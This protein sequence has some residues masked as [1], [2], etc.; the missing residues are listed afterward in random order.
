MLMFRELTEEE[1]QKVD[2]Y[3]EQ[4]QHIANL[5]ISKLEKRKEIEYFKERKSWDFLP[6]VFSGLFLVSQMVILVLDVVFGCLYGFELVTRFAIAI[7]FA[8]MAPI[9]AIVAAVLFVKS[10]N[11]YL[12]RN[13][14]SQSYMQKALR[15]G[16][17][18]RWMRLAKLQQEYE[19]INASLRVLKKENNYL[20][21]AV[22]EIE[23][24]QFQ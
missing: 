8:S 23:K 10:L 11:T 20:K 24:N 22:E 5:E 7:A 13:S 4:K 12:L 19:E 17:E 2:K 6:V 14:K 9:L 3:H 1:K 15:K 21:L 16:V 18:N